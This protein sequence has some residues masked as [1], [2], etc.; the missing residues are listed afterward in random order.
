MP[1]V[2]GMLTF[3]GHAWGV[4]AETGERVSFVEGDKRDVLS[5]ENGR[6]GRPIF[7]LADPDVT[8]IP[9][10]TTMRDGKVAHQGADEPAPTTIRLQIAADAVAFGDGSESEEGGKP[11]RSRTAAKS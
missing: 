4:R 5:Q 8:Y 11:K 7:V 2:I 10:P 9:D 3:K 1:D 6:D